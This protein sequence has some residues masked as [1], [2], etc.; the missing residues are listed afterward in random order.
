MACLHAQDV[1]LEGKFLTDSMELG[2]RIHYSLRAEFPYEVQIIMP[3]SAADFGTFKLLSIKTFNSRLKGDKQIDSVHY[4]LLSFSLDSVQSLRLPVHEYIDGDSSTYYSQKDSLF[5]KKPILKEQL[6][7]DHSHLPMYYRF[8]YQVWLLGSLIVLILIY[9][10]YK[11]FYKRIKRY[12]QKV[13]QKRRFKNYIKVHNQLFKSLQQTK[14][15][16]TLERII[17]NWKESLSDLSGKPISTYTS[18]EINHIYNDPKLYDALRNLDKAIYSKSFSEHLY[19]D[20]EIIY[21]RSKQEF[22]KK[23]RSNA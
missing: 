22:I 17:G 2:Q 23:N 5:L 16:E 19:V 3:D 13:Y 6:L 9:G 12:W 14:S 20:V 1:K 15:I 18:K 4:E 21:N 10:F 7:T 11:T 8:N